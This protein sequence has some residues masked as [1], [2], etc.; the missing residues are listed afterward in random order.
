MSYKQGVKQNHIYMD[1][2]ATTRPYKEVVE[3]MGQVMRE[4]YGNPSSIH[5]M[6]LLAEKVV[7][8]ARNRLAEALDVEAAEIV[9]TSG[10]TESD[11]MAIIGAARMKRR[12][13]R[14]IITSKVEHPAVIEAF[15]YLETKGF[16]AVYV[17]VDNDGIIRMDVLQEAINDDTIL[18]SCM[19]VNNEVGAIQPIKDIAHIKGK[20]LL[21]VDGVQ[22]FGKLPMSIRGVDLLSISGHKICGPKGVGALYVSREIKLPPLIVGGGQERGF[23]SG[24]ENVEAIAGFGLA[25][26]KAV[27]DIYKTKR[28][29][30]TMKEKMAELL[31]AGLKDVKINTPQKSAPGILSITFKKTRGEVLVHTLEQNGIYIST[32]SACSSNK[33]GHS[34]VLKEMGLSSGDIEGTLRISLGESNSMEEVIIVADQI[35][36]AVK[37]FRKLGSFR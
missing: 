21:H 18:I 26:K 9:F 4:E 7:N 11:N 23:R 1:N 6:G 13:G 5:S 31:K 32:G 25:A 19:E 17:P 37:Q 36:K 30:E 20:A 22:S 14:R 24:T 12:S 3:L 15:K 10:G 28:I 29:V 34:Y 2:A 8:Q 27:T 35:I 33:K 16:E